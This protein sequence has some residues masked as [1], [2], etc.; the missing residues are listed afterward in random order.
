MQA[1]IGPQVGANQGVQDP[2]PGGF[3]AAGRARQEHDQPGPLRQ[4]Q[5]LAANIQQAVKLPRGHLLHPTQERGALRPRVPPVRQLDQR[6]VLGGV[7]PLP[8][9]PHVQQAVLE[10]DHRPR[11]LERNH[12]PLGFQLRQRNLG[13]ACLKLRPVVIAQGFRYQPRP[14]EAGAVVE[15]PAL[16]NRHRLVAAHRQVVFTAQVVQAAGWLEIGAVEKGGEL[17]RPFR[18]LDCLVLDRGVDQVAQQLYPALQGWLAAQQIVQAVA[19]AAGARVDQEPHR[20]GHQLA[21]Q[22]LFQPP[23]GLPHHPVAGHIRIESH[24]HVPA[25]HRQR[26]QIGA[27]FQVAAP[28]PA[29]GQAKRDGKGHLGVDRARRG[30]ELLGALHHQH[31]NVGVAP[32]PLKGRIGADDAAAVFGEQVTGWAAVLQGDGSV[33]PDLRHQRP[34]HR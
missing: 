31:R 8:Q 9:L 22:I 11:L 5:H 21:Q 24:Q 10:I 32:V 25:L 27:R 18:G 19:G 3:A 28:A 30:L 12:Q 13:D 33:H 29:A 6:Q 7:V 23:G 17:G 15:H 26:Q 2:D 34:A 4:V 16:I 14:P 1:D 20:P